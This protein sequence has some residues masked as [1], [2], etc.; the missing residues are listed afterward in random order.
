M[1]SCVDSV[2][3]L[4]VTCFAGAADSVW[5]FPATDI[6][7][8]E[9]DDLAVDTGMETFWSADDVVFWSSADTLA[10]A[11][12]FAD[13][14]SEAADE[15]LDDALT[16]VA[17]TVAEFVAVCDVVSVLTGVESFSGSDCVV[18]LLVEAVAPVFTCAALFCSGGLAGR[19]PLLRW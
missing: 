4:E 16:S 1:R 11:G 2:V 12:V 10:V 15:L 3:G 19:S 6:S 17:L 8:L 18:D 5:D 13:D 14:A 9:A 7:L